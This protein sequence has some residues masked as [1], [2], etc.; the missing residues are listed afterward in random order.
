MFR[1]GL[2]LLFV[3]AHSAEPSIPVVE[4]KSPDDWYVYFEDM[5]FRY[6]GYHSI[7]YEKKSDLSVLQAARDFSLAYLRKSIGYHIDTAGVK[8][9][10][11]NNP[12]NDQTVKGIHLIE[13]NLKK[14]DTFNST[15]FAADLGAVL[16][17]EH[18]PKRIGTLCHIVV[19]LGSMTL[20]AHRDYEENLNERIRIGEE[21]KKNIPQ[22]EPV[23]TNQ[24]AALYNTAGIESSTAARLEILKNRL[25]YTRRFVEQILNTLPSTPATFIRDPAINS[26]ILKYVK[27][28]V[29]RSVEPSINDIN[30]VIEVTMR[31]ERMEKSAMKSV[32]LSCLEC[33][34]QLIKHA[35]GKEQ[36]GIERRKEI[37]DLIEEFSASL[38][39]L[40]L[41]KKK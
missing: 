17:A 40:N 12:S 25:Q 34:D 29:N 27:A 10:I 37:S 6:K 2:F 5:D 14:M 8:K 24:L 28:V 41:Y 4:E 9:I 18:R 19:H 7:L 15:I 23:Y 21:I 36:A 13:S 1:F 3:F 35:A 26:R 38:T 39:Q 33:V 32:A 20:M 22:I 11:E 30:R 31:E 16:T